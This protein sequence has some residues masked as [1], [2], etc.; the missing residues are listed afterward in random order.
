MQQQIRN[1]IGNLPC[2]FGIMA[3]SLITTVFHAHAQ[4]LEPRAYTNTPVGMNF[5]LAGYSYA[6]GALLFDPSLPV[7]DANA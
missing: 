1:A 2:M 6:E 5:L 3:F 4:T 7:T